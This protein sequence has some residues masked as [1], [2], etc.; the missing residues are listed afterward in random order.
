MN[1]SPSVEAGPGEGEAAWNAALLQVEYARRD[2]AQCL[3]SSDRDESE[4]ARLWQ[5]L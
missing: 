2:Y 3:R 5:R 4:L 1:A